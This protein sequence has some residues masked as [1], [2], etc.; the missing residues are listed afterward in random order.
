MDEKKKVEKLRDIILNEI[1]A[2]MGGIDVVCWDKGCK[3]AMTGDL[4][5]IDVVPGIDEVPVK[6]D[7]NTDF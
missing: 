4:L 2:G 5:D 1:K 3:Y 7:I 6:K